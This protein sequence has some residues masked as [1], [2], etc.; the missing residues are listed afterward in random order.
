MEITKKEIER[1]LKQKILTKDM[2][3]SI[4]KGKTK[5]KL[6]REEFNQLMYDDDNFKEQWGGS[7]KQDQTNAFLEWASLYS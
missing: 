1:L 7:S 2:V 6:M 5:R 3:K 4:Q